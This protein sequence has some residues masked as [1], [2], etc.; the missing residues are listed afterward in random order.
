MGD[1]SATRRRR[2]L[3]ALRVRGEGENPSL[4]NGA[5]FT[6]GTR[7]WIQQ[8]GGRDTWPEA[9]VTRTMCR[10]WHRDLPGCP[11]SGVGLEGGASAS[12]GWGG[13]HPR[14]AA[15]RSC[16]PN[17]PQDRDHG[18]ERVPGQ[19]AQGD[20]PCRPRAHCALWEL[21]AWPTEGGHPGDVRVGR[22]DGTMSPPPAG[23]GAQWAAGTGATGPVGRPPSSSWCSWPDILVSVLRVP[24]G[25]AEV[26]NGS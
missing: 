21:Q 6:L 7:V 11:R 22:V 19:R 18:G 17:R 12:S 10:S 25:R 16:R 3:Q 26:R 23:R 13:L 8:A 15:V 4:G 2:T 9:A 5:G 24:N 1:T 14:M 20:R